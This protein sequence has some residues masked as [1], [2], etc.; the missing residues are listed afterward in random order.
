MN[1]LL[2]FLFL[3]FFAATFLMA[4][5]S[6]KAKT[7]NAF[8][9]L[10]NKNE[11]VI[12]VKGESKPFGYYENGEFKGF[13][14]DVAKYVF[15]EVFKGKKLIF[16]EVTAQNKITKLN[17][18]EVDFIVAIMSAT[19]SRAKVVDFSNPYFVAGQAIMVKKG[20]KINTIDKLNY[21]NVAIVL[22]TTG[23]RTL[24]DFAPKASIKGSKSYD[25]AFQ[26][27]KNNKVEAI[28][29]DDAILYGIITENNGYVIL[30]KRYTKEFYSIALFKQ[31]GNEELKLKI[32][33]VLDDMQKKGVLNKINKKWIP[34]TKQEK[35][36]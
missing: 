3:M 36:I 5:S 24:R 27:L 2:S 31:S 28:Y 25:E 19:P 13:D 30:D 35:K 17:S 26:L 18:K 4:C 15:N 8:E 12:G 1:K 34:N 9:E 6:N 33:T 22:G 21:K 23:E 29:G 10:N 7:I 14:V 11:I 16:K 32:N 20:S